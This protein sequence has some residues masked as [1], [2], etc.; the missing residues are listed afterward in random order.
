MTTIIDELVANIKSNPR[1]KNPH[2]ALDLFIEFLS[3]NK[4][5]VRVLTNMHSYYLKHRVEDLSK[6]L[7]SQHK[8]QYEYCG[9]E[10][11][12]QAAMNADFVSK[13]CKSMYGISPNFHFNIKNFEMKEVYDWVEN[14]LCKSV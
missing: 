9:N 3:E 1:P 8:W 2:K 10:E 4:Q 6:Y 11:F 13:R 14:K 5:S 7:V 12:I